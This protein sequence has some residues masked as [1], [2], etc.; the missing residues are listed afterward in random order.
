ML[1]YDLEIFKTDRVIPYANCIYRLSKFSGKFQRHV[2]DWDFE[3]LRKDLIV[4]KGTNSFY[5]MLDLNL[6]F[7]GEAKKVK[8][9]IV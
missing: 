7:K 4:F 2:T 5:E 9:K 6:Q 3:K 1:V 8:N